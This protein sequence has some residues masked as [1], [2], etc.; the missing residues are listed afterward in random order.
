[1]MIKMEDKKMTG[2][3]MSRLSRKRNEE[4]DCDWFIAVLPVSQNSRAIDR[5][6][7]SIIYA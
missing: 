6:V 5:R 1:M 7:S 2:F 3:K 4:M